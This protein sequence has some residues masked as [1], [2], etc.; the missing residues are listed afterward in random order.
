MG[1]ISW[2]TESLRLG[3]QKFFE[4]YKR[5]PNVKEVDKFEYLPTARTI[6]RSFGGMTAL[7]QTLGLDTP[8]DHRSGETRA[9]VASV[10]DK[11]AQ[12]YEK[13]FY[14]HLVARVP[15][16]RVHEHKIIRPGDTAADFFIYTNNSEGIVIDLFYAADMHSL[17]GIVN[18]KSK[19]YS[20]VKFPVY[21]VLVGNDKI[22]QESIDRKMNN[23]KNILPLHIRVVT[24]ANFKEQLDG[25]V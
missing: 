13:E 8:W 5:Y 7:R 11:R 14:E 1:K 15:E 21:F 4:T 25:L 17:G 6:Q 24:E 9:K 22:T 20:G 16:V 12:V 3:F 18:I 19:K 10:A 23:R 2:D